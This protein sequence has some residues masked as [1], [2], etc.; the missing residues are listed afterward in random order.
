MTNVLPDQLTFLDKKV[1]L[2]RNK[3]GRLVS[4]RLRFPVN[5]QREGDGLPGWIRKE[6]VSL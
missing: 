1:V 6:S 3:S 4:A 5:D 2:Y